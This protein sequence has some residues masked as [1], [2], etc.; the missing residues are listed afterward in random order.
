[1]LIEG[2]DGT[3]GFR[4]E[5]ARDLV[6]GEMT[7]ARRRL[8]HR[9]AATALDARG[10]RDTQGAVIAHH[11]AL[12]GEESEAAALY[13]VAGD[14][15]SD[16]YANAEALR[17][18]RAALAHGH[19]AQEELHAAIGDLETLA[20][21]YGA[22]LA[23]YRTAAALASPI[24][25][26]AIEH[27]I[28]V[29]HL[30]RGEWEL[31]DASLAVALEASDGE[32]AARITAD[33]SLV[34]H[35]RRLPDEALQLAATAL[36][37]AERAGD[38]RARAQARNILGILATNRGDHTTAV[39]ELEASLVLAEEAGDSSARAAALNNLALAVAAGGDASRAIELTAAGIEL[40]VTL[41]DRHREAALRNNLADV[42]H[43]AGR[44]DEAMGELKQAVAIFAEVGE[45]GRLEPEIWKLS[46]W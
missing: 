11:L 10:R 9:R 8:L 44:K 15:A 27:R 32:A 35:R 12:G 42:L 37:L 28:G 6:Y 21:D 34:A 30:R 33:R 36:E 29:L 45:E 14:R 25:A 38:L 18:Y 22:A 7:L 41:G 46:E 39:A 26:P 20:G 2:N 4:H 24:L 5:Q 23:S 1:V 3:L 19:V 13:R 43:A 31:A 17:Y 16:L 40:T